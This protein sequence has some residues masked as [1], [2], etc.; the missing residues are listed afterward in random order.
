MNLTPLGPGSR[1]LRRR[2]PLAADAAFVGGTRNQPPTVCIVV[3]PLAPPFRQHRRRRFISPRAKPWVTR[4]CSK[5]F[6]KPQ[7]GEQKAAQATAPPPRS[8]QRRHADCEKEQQVDDRCCAIACSRK[9][10]VHRFKSQSPGDV[11]LA[12]WATLSGEICRDVPRSNVNY[13]IGH[14]S[15]KAVRQRLPSLGRLPLE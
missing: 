11:C 2:S 1:F 15:T 7:R 10:R 8:T 4:T 6:R 5:S 13:R 3:G 12:R 9:E 14:A